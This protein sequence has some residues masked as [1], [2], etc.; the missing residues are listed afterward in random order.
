MG[1]RMKLKTREQYL[2][3]VKCPHCKNYFDVDN[4]TINWFKDNIEKPLK[5][6][7]HNAYA[8]LGALDDSD[9]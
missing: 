3:H 1:V 6:K 5:E 4:D 2:L 9:D 8:K 7:L